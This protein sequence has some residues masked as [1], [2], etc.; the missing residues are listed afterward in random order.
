MS[1]LASKCYTTFS[2][3]NI[4][5]RVLKFVFV[6]VWI[7]MFF[8]SLKC[9]HFWCFEH[10]YVCS[11]C[12]VINSSV[13]K[14]M[15]LIYLII[16]KYNIACICTAIILVYVLYQYYLMLLYHFIYTFNRRFFVC[17]TNVFIFRKLFLLLF[18]PFL[19]FD[20]R[21]LNWKKKLH[22]WY[23]ILVSLYFFPEFT[24]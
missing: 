8:L 21:V 7:I 10:L 1:P 3:K 9:I 23:F 4:F 15:L 22:K 20:S 14:D 13:M 11:M 6:N 18:S 12:P 2:K 24:F 17:Y 5:V 19:K 16:F